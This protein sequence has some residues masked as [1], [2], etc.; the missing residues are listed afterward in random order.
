MK[1]NRFLALAAIAMLVVAAMGF[2]SAKSYAQTATPPAPAAVQADQPDQP[3][4]VTGSNTG[5]AVA[6]ETDGGA[7]DQTPSYTGSITVTDTANLSEADEATALA[8][9]ARIT[10][11]QAKA[12]ALA[13]NPGATVVKAELDNEN[14]ALVYSVELSTGADVKVDAGNGAILHTDTGNDSGEVTN[15]PDTD[16]VQ[17]GQGQQVEDGQP[18]VPGAVEVPDAAPQNPA[19]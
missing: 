15:D 1:I 6:T 16:N 11:E 9:Q 12:A 7:N 14:G 18:D 17:E 8:G 10:I 3:E 13:A 5:A 2:V 19:Q 4:A